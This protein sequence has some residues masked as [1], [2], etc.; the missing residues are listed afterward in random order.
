[1][2]VGVTASATSLLF[3]KG[4]FALFV[5][6]DVAFSYD[7][8]CTGSTLTVRSVVALATGFRVTVDPATP[9]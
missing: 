6:S 4:S 5:I 1:M 3:I 8:I 7:L 9:A 2:S